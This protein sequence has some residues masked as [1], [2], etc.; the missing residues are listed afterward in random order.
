VKFLETCHV[1]G[2]QVESA[3]IIGRTFNGKGICKGCAERMLVGSP[4]NRAVSG[5]ELSRRTA[6][7]RQRDSLEHFQKNVR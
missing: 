4:S 1:C 5:S 7:Q 6:D 3:L 2:E